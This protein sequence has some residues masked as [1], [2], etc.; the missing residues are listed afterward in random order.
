MEDGGCAKTSSM[1]LVH[2]V[3][4]TG[5]MFSHTPLCDLTDF[6]IIFAG[7]PL[8]CVRELFFLFFFFFFFIKLFGFI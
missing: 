6:L 2:A 1:A 4:G 3:Q 8:W 7:Q 5:Q